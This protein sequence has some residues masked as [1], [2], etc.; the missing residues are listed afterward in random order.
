MLWSID[1]LLG[2]KKQ[3]WEWTKSWNLKEYDAQ[4]KPHTDVYRCAAHRRPLWE[5]HVKEYGG[6]LV[7]RANIKHSHGTKTPNET[8]F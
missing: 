6:Y 2:K 1:A 4:N 3:M 5:L 8:V 7:T